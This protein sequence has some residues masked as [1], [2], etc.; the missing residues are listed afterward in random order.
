MPKIVERMLRA[1][2]GRIIKKLSGL[3]DQVNA[4]EEDF[5]R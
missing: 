2:E 5:A 3:A 1:G 4:L